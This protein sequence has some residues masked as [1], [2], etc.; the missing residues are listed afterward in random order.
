MNV[1]RQKIDPKGEII[2]VQNGKAFFLMTRC[3]ITCQTKFAI[4]FI[5]KIHPVKKPIRSLR[6]DA[7]EHPVAEMVW[8]P[9]EHQTAL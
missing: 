9:L 3:G 4:V 2:P 1:S 7:D 6:L 8:T 5:D